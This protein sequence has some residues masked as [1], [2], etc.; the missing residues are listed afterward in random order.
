[1]TEIIKMIDTSEHELYVNGEK[2][3]A[4]SF[5]YDELLKGCEIQPKHPEK[6]PLIY[7]HLKNGGKWIHPTRMIIEVENES[8]IR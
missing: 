6:E 1:M 7:Y 2:V 3:D 4:I 5:N 8:N